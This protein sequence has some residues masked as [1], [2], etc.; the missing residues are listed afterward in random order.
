M[1]PIT[2]LRAA[3]DALPSNILAVL[4][5]LAAAGLFASSHAGVRHLTDD[6]HPFVVAFFR[7]FFAFLAFAPWFAKNGLSGLQTRRP[8]LHFMRGVVNAAAILLWFSA[9]SM[10]AFADATALSLT[11]PLFAMAGAAMIFGETI[12]R[13]RWT[14]LAVG[15]AG[16]LIIIRPGFETISLGALLVIAR[17][18]T[19]AVSKLMAKSLTRTEPTTTIVAWVML[20]MV[21]IS[22]PPALFF[23][24]WP[25]LLDYVWLAFVGGAGA[26][27]NIFMVKGYK[28]AD[29]SAVEPITFT[30]LVWAALI[31]YFFFAEVPDIWVWAGGATIVAA[32]TYLSRSGRKN[33]P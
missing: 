22:L 8:G 4:L 25:G 18:M 12:G 29:V 26:L 14:A 28:L 17:A 23:W 11:G 1:S 7:N 16:A 20:W 10:M 32:T 31:G 21:P 3:V 15:L 33:N 27:A 5:V 19:Q 6:L 2:R 24:Q 9:L 13:R 30:R